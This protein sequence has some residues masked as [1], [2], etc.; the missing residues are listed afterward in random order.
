MRWKY[1]T[2]TMLEE[3]EEEYNY[4]WKKNN[5]IY[6]MFQDSSFM[7]IPEYDR[8]QLE[9]QYC[10]QNLYLDILTN[11]LE[12]HGENMHRKSGLVYNELRYKE[13]R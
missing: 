9:M 10:A 1:M 4:L 7:E 5:E 6:K 12:F 11:R 2:E 3:L 8:V 13:L